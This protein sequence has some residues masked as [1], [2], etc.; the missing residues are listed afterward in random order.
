LF[1]ALVLGLVL[2]W[3]LGWSIDFA[4][5]DSDGP[6]HAMTRDPCARPDVARFL[7]VWGIGLAGVAGVSLIARAM[8]RGGWWQVSLWAGF[9]LI[10]DALLMFQYV[11]LLPNP[12]CNFD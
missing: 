12:P 5:N 3:A 10:A 2:L 11:R 6:A 4:V 1:G 7:L 8:H 9:I